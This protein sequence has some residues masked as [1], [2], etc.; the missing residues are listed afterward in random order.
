VFPG[1]GCPVP[2]S[3]ASG[4]ASAVSKRVH[5]GADAS[6]AIAMVGGNLVS[7]GCQ[8]IDPDI[9]GGCNMQSHL[10]SLRLARWT[11][12]SGDLIKWSRPS[13]SGMRFSC[14]GSLRCTMAPRSLSPLRRSSLGL[15]RE[16][17]RSGG[18]MTFMLQC[19]FRRPQTSARWFA[20]ALSGSF[21]LSR[22]FPNCGRSFWGGQFYSRS[23]SLR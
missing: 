21:I 11:A 19:L 5:E 1:S 3:P 2:E 7:F 10:K 6:R 4:T 23:T 14:V 18:A 20:P 9:G 16:C 13:R 22:F 12:R 17:C 15:P 8:L